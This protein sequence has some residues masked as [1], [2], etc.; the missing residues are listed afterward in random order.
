MMVSISQ[1]IYLN[2]IFLYSQGDLLQGYDYSGS[3]TEQMGMFV[4]FV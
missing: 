2:N 1:D 4:K 3:F